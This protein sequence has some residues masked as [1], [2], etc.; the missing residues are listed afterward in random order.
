MSEAGEDG[1]APLTRADL[2]SGGGLTGSRARL[3]LLAVGI[4]IAGVVIGRVTAPDE[5]SPSGDGGG[6]GEA[7]GL[8]FPSGD[9][10]RTGYWG[11]VNLEPI[12]IDTFDRRDD[13]RSLG[14]AGT[15]QVWETPA[16]TWGIVDQ[17]AV[18]DGGSGNDP[19]LAVVPRGT[20]DGLTE[21]TM[22]VVE[23]GAGLVFRY[24]DPENYWAVTANPSVGSW[25]VT[26]VIDGEDELVGELT[27]PTVN[28]TTVSV[29]QDG[30][31]LR[32]LLEGQ[33]YLAVTDGALAEQLQGGLIASPGSQGDARWD[34]YLVMQF[35]DDEAAATTTA[36]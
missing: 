30:S 34:R 18:T 2:G 35:G 29:V 36:P 27:G 4:L 22:T 5:S 21:V 31:S 26:R 11:F 32:F 28:A 12:T 24:L 20:G 7:E 13:P 16:G 19:S 1:S 15:G 25:S 17:S 14:S 33:E 8:P 6:A 10:N 23:D 3:A 9:V